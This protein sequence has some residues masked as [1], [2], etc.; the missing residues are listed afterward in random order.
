VPERGAVAI[1]RRE[2]ISAKYGVLAARRS[3]RVVLARDLMMKVIV[4]WS[5]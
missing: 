1:G 3:S 2:D 5:E 4:V